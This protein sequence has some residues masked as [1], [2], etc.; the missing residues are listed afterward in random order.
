MTTEASPRLSA[1]GSAGCEIHT[2]STEG[3]RIEVEIDGIA[4]AVTEIS[5]KPR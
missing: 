2:C 3:T 1:Y 5:E 4:G